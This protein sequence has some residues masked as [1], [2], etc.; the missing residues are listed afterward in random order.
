VSHIHVC[1]VSEQTIPNI[2]S[3]HHFKPDD[4]LFVSTE[5][6]ESNKT[7][8]HMLK[9][10]SYIDRDFKERHQKIVVKEDSLLDCKKRLDEW[11]AGR[12]SA[13]FTVNLT[14]GTKIMS[15][16]SRLHRLF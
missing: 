4:V 7:V 8:E 6:M 3:I 16:L 15:I 11:I 13:E 12:E 10:L 5:K 9:T 14:G 2:L 1:L